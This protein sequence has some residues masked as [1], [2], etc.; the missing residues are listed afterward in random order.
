LELQFQ[1]LQFHVTHR[2]SDRLLFQSLLLALLAFFLLL[3]IS[4]PT[5]LF[6]LLESFHFFGAGIRLLRL[7][8]R[9]GRRQG[10]SNISHCSFIKGFGRHLSRTS[11][12]KLL[13]VARFHLFELFI[14]LGFGAGKNKKDKESAFEI[15]KYQVHT[16]KGNRILFV[17]SVAYLAKASFPLCPLS[18]FAFLM[19]D[20]FS[21]SKTLISFL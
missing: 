8:Q 18:D 20:L 15:L 4:F 6:H 12:G 9:Y 16:R 2:W 10:S 19:A 14:E 17:E 3:G 13:Q 5:G 21:P 7:C 11:V 1:G